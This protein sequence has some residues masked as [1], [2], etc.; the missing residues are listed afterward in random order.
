[1]KIAL[2]KC[3]LFA[4]AAVLLLSFKWVGSVD[5]LIANLQFKFSKYIER[6]TTEKI[7]LHIDK[8]SFTTGQNIW[9]KVYLCNAITG[10][11]INYQTIA[12]VELLS[13]NQYISPIPRS[14]SA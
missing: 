1:M 4:M 6:D 3:F 5:V 9:T 8:Q 10:K 11:P 2:Y 7:Y 12:Y 13:P 14:S